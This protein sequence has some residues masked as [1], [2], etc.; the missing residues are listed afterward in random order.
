MVLHDILPLDLLII[1]LLGEHRVTITQ[2]NLW[3]DHEGS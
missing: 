1:R 2:H 3:K